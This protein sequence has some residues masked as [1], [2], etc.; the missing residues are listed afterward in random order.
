MGS[1]SMPYYTTS[2]MALHNS[3]M[4]GRTLYMNDAFNLDMN[5]L[6]LRSL[7]YSYFIIQIY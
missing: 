7:T 6:M 2:L 5:I 3:Q 4:V 1:Y